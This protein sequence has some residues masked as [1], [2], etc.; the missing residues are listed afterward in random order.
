MIAIS[1]WRLKMG[2]CSVSCPMNSK[3]MRWFLFRC[4]FPMKYINRM[5]PVMAS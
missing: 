2:T 1:A 4:N 3:A 5:S